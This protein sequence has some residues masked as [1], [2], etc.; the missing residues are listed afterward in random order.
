MDLEDLEKVTQALQTNYKNQ[1]IRFIKTDVTKKDE[2]K[3]AFAEAVSQF[4]FIDYVVANAGI[5][6]EKD[7]E[8]TINVNVVI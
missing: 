7:Y 8:L 4:N 6:R 3:N 5:L 1:K 2:V